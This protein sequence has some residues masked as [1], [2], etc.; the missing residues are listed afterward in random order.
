MQ[1]P[2]YQSLAPQPQGTLEPCVQGHHDTTLRFGLCGI[3]MA[4]IFFPVGLLCLCLD[5]RRVCVR[6]GTVVV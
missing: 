3:L 2:P 5:T 1:H 6:C 4:I